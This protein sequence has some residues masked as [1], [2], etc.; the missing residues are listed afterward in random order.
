MREFGDVELFRY[1][2]PICGSLNKRKIPIM[3]KGVPYGYTLH[4]CN[5]GHIEEFIDP[6]KHIG[7]LYNG[8]FTTG[9]ESEQTCYQLNACP[10]TDCPL[11]GTYIPDENSGYDDELNQDKPD[12]PSTPNKRPSFCGQCTLCDG[13]GCIPACGIRQYGVYG[14]NSSVE[15]EL[16]VKVETKGPKFV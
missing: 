13:T 6:V 14:N 15:R 16:E 12:K 8:H 10:Y 7:G 1:K 5:C 3:Y 4:C 9:K 2:C 11:Y